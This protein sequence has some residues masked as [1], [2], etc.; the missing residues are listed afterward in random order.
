MRLNP[1][2]LLAAGTLLHTACAV[3]CTLL[4][5]PGLAVQLEGLVPSEYTITLSSPDAGSVS[6]TCSSA[7]P[8]PSDLIRFVGYA[9]Q[10]VTVSVVGATSSVGITVQPSYQT[11]Y[12]NGPK[13][14]A[15][16]TATITI[17]FG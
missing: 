16:R 5:C 10:E 7:T 8:C 13:C 1:L 14:G 2:P 11:V 6:R 3:E 12:P 15:C 9:P 17:E 4:P